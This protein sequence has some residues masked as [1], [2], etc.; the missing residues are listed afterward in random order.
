MSG[1]LFALEASAEFECVVWIP[2]HGRTLAECT[3]E[4]G[5]ELG[6]TMDETEKQNRRRVLDALQERRCLV[7]L[8]AP[9]DEARAALEVGG[10]SSMLVT[11]E[12]LEVRE[13]PRT[14]A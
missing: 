14:F 9:S 1:S 3:G 12:P 13:T 5:A 4:L 8:D 11:T 6:L 2:C 10:R 7:I